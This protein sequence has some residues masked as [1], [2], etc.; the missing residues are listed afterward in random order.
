MEAY[1]SMS[2]AASFDQ[3]PH[4]ELLAD[5]LE[6]RAP[7]SIQ[8]GTGEPPTE[9]RGGDT[10]IVREAW[11]LLRKSV[12]S[13]NGCPVGTVAALEHLLPEIVRNFL[14]K[15]LELQSWER[16]T[17]CFSPGEGLLPA[18]FKV[19][20]TDHEDEVEADFGELAIGR[21]APVDSGLWWI[22]L[23]RAYTEA[24]GDQ[25]LAQMPEFQKGIRLILKLLA[26]EFD[27]FPTMLVTDGCCMIDR[28]MGIDG[29]PLEIQSLFYNALR[30][31]H[32]L[33]RRDEHNSVLLR[34]IEKRL[35]ALSA[36]I[37]DY[38]W[39][40]INQ[41]NNIY[42][43]KTEEY[44]DDAVNKFNVYPDSIP[45]WVLD[46]MPDV[47]GYLIGNLGP[48]R[49]DF[50]YFALGNLMAILCSLTT[51]QQAEAIMDLYESRWE[52]LIAAMPL[53][54][55]YPALEGSYH[56][57]GSWPTLLWVFT[58]A[59]LKA[60]RLKLAQRAIEQAERRLAKDHWPEY[61]DGKRGRLI[62]KQNPRFLD[63][64]CFNEGIVPS[65]RLPRDL[66]KRPP[67]PQS[68]AERDTSISQIA[69]SLSRFSMRPSSAG[70]PDSRLGS[71]QL[72]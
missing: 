42:R 45:E 62:G 57:G 44:S 68:G 65:V 24:T 27:M 33:L 4:K 39:L 47:G 70:P 12:M 29:H 38:Y 37:R 26:D 19:L 72:S 20:H 53:K 15:T 49:M 63:F 43:Y 18:S 6:A 16:Q 54:L 22:F 8:N 14:L 46:W 40:D 58:A 30:C 28:R 60:G 64:I 50:R 10:P 1:G 7:H 13:F 2:P 11:E 23:L 32:T 69:S 56:N 48:A 61:Y 25:S 67:T 55:C 59:C 41:L 31:S 17:D 35:T 52:D 21:V 3:I 51:S 9:D 66:K 5:A 36:H 71:R 34:M